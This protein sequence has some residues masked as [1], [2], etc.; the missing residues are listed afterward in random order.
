[1]TSKWNAAQV[2]AIVL[3]AGATVWGLATGSTNRACDDSELMSI[4]GGTEN[5]VCEDIVGCCG[6]NIECSSH[7]VVNKEEGAACGKKTQYDGLQ[8]CN[9]A[10]SGLNCERNP[11]GIQ[12]KFACWSKYECIAEE[13]FWSED[14]WICREVGVGSCEVSN[15]SAQASGSP[16]CVQNP[17]YK[18]EY[19][20]HEYCI[21]DPH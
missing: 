20:Y 18:Q 13:D 7:T 16:G 19:P 14:G 10:A 9:A 2:V 1:M 12:Q 3:F 4:V 8:Q 11:T 5:G 15:Q 6:D 17:C 21:G